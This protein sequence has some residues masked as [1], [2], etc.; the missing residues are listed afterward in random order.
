MRDPAYRVAREVAMRL[1]SEQQLHPP[2]DI[3]KVA[4]RFACVEERDIPS[5]VDVLTLHATCPTGAPRIVINTNLRERKARRRFAIAHGLAHVLLGWHPLSAPC[6]VSY[7]PWELPSTAHA[8]I[9][10]EANAFSRELLMPSSWIA[11]FNASDRP[12]LLSCHVAERSGQELMP[13]ARAVAGLLSPGFVWCVSDQWDRVIDGGRS[14]GTSIKAPRPEHTTQIDVLARH[15]SERHRNDL[16]DQTIT[17]WRFDDSA[18]HL[19]PHDRTSRMVLNDIGHDLHLSEKDSALLAARVEGVAGWANARLDT[20]S[21]ADMRSALV[22]RSHSIPDLS[23]LTS[24]QE[25]ASLV[26]AKA[27]EL[28]ARRLAR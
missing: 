11:G 2:F 26:D 9:E 20:A 23:I 10:G 14:P 19:L 5:E 16:R 6:D 22:A 15:A 4:S 12:A 24:H 18:L 13:A 3:E 27:T 17:F 21:I 28:V 8:L 1:A 7:R 25:F